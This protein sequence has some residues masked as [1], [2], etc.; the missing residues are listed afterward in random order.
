[1]HDVLDIAVGVLVDRQG[2]LLIAERRPDTPGAGY[3]EFPG[4]KHEEGESI[5]DCLAREL[6]EEIGVTDIAGAPLIRFM[7]NRGPRPVRLHVWRIHNW[8]GEPGGREGQQVRWATRAQLDA[9]ALLP[10]TDVILAALA[11]PRRYLITPSQVDGNRDGWFAALDT[12]LASGVR[13]LRLRDVKRSDTEYADLAT[14]VIER[15]HRHN[16]AVMLDRSADMVKA[17]N[18]DGLHWN[19]DR[20]AA[21]KQRPIGATYWFAASAHDS[22]ELDAALV[23]G[24][25]FATVSPL[26]KTRSHPGSCPLGWPGFEAL[27]CDRALPVYALGGLETTDEKDALAHNAQGIAAIRGLWSGLTDHS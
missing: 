26:A 18:A 12:A 20:I 16:V 5:A 17:L 6:T 15:A 25:D 19:A 13:L 14:A 11:L 3:W 27:R 24:A 7:H 22:H 2:R 1:M 10:A 21:A 8:T 4:G 23:V 9:F